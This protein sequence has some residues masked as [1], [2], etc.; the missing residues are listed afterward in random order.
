MIDHYR[1]LLQRY[2]WLGDHICW[3]VVRPLDEGLT[4]DDVLWR[5]NG[6]R[7]PEHRVMAFPREEAAMEEERPVFLVHE[8]EGAWG[9]LEFSLGYAVPDDVLARVSED[10]QSWMV[11]WHF[12]GGA[13]VLYAAGGRV[14]AWM[15]DFVLS[16][17]RREGGDPDVLAGFRA[18]LDTLGP[19]DHDGRRAA[20]LAFVEQATGVGI[21]RDC[22]D[23]KDA[24]VVILG[25]PV[26]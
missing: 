19:E 2:G 13:T 20:A 21:E 6:G 26:A 12:N 18:L 9:L 14:R 4:V 5:L 11:T 10:V 3:I 22:M 17:Q 15:R 24:P 16:G 8:D 1:D 23:V 7:D 25:D